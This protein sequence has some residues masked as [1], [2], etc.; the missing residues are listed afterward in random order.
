MMKCLLYIV[1]L[2]HASYPINC[3]VP[4]FHLCKNDSFF[5]CDIYTIG[6]CL[7][8]PELLDS[9]QVSTKQVNYSKAISNHY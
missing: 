1:D 4:Y 7:A 3:S 6:K 5:L 2:F 9:I 8:Q